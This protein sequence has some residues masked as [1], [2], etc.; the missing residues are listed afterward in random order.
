MSFL[1]N[2]ISNWRGGLAGIT[3]FLLVW[4]VAFFIAFMTAFGNDTPEARIILQVFSVFSAAANPLWG[5][6]LSYIAGSY[7]ALRRVP[8]EEGP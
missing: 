6:P 2:L 7:L 1:N 5:I 3:V 8:V 4:A